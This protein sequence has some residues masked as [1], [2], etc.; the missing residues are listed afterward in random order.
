MSSAFFL[1]LPH[2]EKAVIK[3][4]PLSITKENISQELLLF[5]TQNILDEKVSISANTTLSDAGIDSYAVI[6][7]VLY[8]ER[9]FGIAIKEKDM[10]P[11]NFK[12]VETLT[13]CAITYL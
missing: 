1:L 2:Q 4:T 7:L 12:S 8:L 11:E 5:I 13:N 10:V 3:P 9:K 6:E